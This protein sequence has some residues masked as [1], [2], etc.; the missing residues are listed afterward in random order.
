[1]GTKTQQKLDAFIVTS[2]F[3]LKGTS[4]SYVSRYLDKGQIPADV[5][6]DI[7]AKAAGRIEHMARKALPERQAQKQKGTSGISGLPA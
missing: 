4:A 6:L 1:M 7:I 5:S 2:R 3:G